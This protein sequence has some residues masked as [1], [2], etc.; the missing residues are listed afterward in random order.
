M[1]KGLEIMR[2]ANDNLSLEEEEDEE[3]KLKVGKNGNGSLEQ[4]K[5]HEK[6]LPQ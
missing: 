5:T 3:E 2:Y 1:L 6:L 4:A